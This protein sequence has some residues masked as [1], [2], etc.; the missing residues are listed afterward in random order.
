MQFKIQ[1][2][3][4]GQEYNVNYL[5]TTLQNFQTVLIFQVN[6]HF[7]LDATVLQKQMSKKMV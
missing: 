1:M 4:L 5:L 6:N 3:V 2:K 7:G